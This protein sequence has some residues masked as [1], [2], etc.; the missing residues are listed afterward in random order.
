MM[1]HFVPGS[2]L[3]SH[4]PKPPLRLVVSEP[5]KPDPKTV[6]KPKPKSE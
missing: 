3:L 6:K 2:K 4:K 5:V 1:A